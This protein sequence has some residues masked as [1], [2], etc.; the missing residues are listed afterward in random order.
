M[1]R[2]GRDN[3]HNYWG[4]AKIIQVWQG[5]VRT[6]DG[7]L[8]IFSAKEFSEP[9]REIRIYLGEVDSSHFFAVH[10]EIDKEF[11]EFQNLREIV[12]GLPENEIGILEAVVTAIALCNWH[13]T[14]PQ[15][16]RCG[17]ETKVISNGW[18]RKCI[19]DGSQ[20]FPRTDP[21]IIVAVQ[22]RSGRI[23]LG[24]QAHWPEGRY[25]NFAG[26]VEPGESLEATVVR[27]VGEESGLVVSEIKYL[28][29]Q[30]WPF[31]NSIMLAFEA[32]TDN[33]EAARPD[34]S[35]IVDLKWF[36]RDELRTAVADGTLILP[37][38]TTVSGKLIAGWLNG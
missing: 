3:A 11:D 33:P 19:S 18:V 2:A 30:P 9:E 13:E 17:Q 27:E 28:S 24:R 26:F 31:P 34:G 8:K 6:Q 35:E 14:H 23:C 12:A 10:K 29:S 7:Q 32:F 1:N 36:S 5:D 16:P 38:K 20:H 25:S 37:P 22:D 21:A 4:D 15:C